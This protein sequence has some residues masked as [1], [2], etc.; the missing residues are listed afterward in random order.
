MGIDIVTLA[1][2]RKYVNDTANALGA[3]KGAPCTIKAVEE[4]DSGNIITFGWIGT[5]GS[6]QTTQ[7]TIRHGTGEV[8]INEALER[9][10][11]SLVAAEEA[12]A[13]ANAAAERATRAV[14]VTVFE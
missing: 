12:T 11:A 5:D 7:I 2:A 1:L 14:T 10:D 13:N 3:V 4:T 8:E 6:E 9:I